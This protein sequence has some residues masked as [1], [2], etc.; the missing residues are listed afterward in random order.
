MY[1]IIEYRDTYPSEPRNNLGKK[2]VIR[3]SANKYLVRVKL[4]FQIKKEKLHDI[5]G[6]IP[7]RKK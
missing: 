1:K 3:Y 7:G 2:K 4:S 5:Q 6:E